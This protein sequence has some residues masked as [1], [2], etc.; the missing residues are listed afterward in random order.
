MQISIPYGA[1]K[2]LYDRFDT[3]LPLWISIPYGAI[4]R[5]H[6]TNG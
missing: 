4:K 5:T 6:A 1:I 3:A 2:R